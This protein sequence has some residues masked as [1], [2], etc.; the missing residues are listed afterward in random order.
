[1]LP[2]FFFIF[3]LLEKINTSKINLGRL[4]VLGDKKFITLFADI[5]E[6]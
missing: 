1:V 3:D 5:Q 4:L 6:E 2:P